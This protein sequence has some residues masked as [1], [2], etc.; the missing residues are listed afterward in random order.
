M[1]GGKERRGDKGRI[2]RKNVE[3]GGALVDHRRPTATTRREYLNPQSGAL[4]T[5]YNTTQQT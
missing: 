4:A 2:I 1:F 3:V 5:V